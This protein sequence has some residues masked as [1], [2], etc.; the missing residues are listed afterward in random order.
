MFALGR[1]IAAAIERL[2]SGR[3]HPVVRALIAPRG[4]RGSG[5]DGAWTRHDHRRVVMI[6][7]VAVIIG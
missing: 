2:L 5:P 6:G 7:I 3:E 4:A 1:R